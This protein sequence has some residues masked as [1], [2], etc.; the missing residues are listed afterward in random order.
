LSERGIIA[1]SCLFITPFSL[2]DICSLKL[3]MG[4]IEYRNCKVLCIG[5]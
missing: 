3:A 5:P 1:S 4:G 2:V